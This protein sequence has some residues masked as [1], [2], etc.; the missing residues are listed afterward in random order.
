MEVGQSTVVENS[1]QINGDHLQNIRYETS[2]P[3]RNNK[4]EYLKGK[5]NEL[6]TNNK[7]NNIRYLYR[8]INQFRKGYQPGINIIKHENGN[9]LADPQSVLNRWKDFLNQV[10]N[11]HGIQD[12]R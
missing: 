2:R 11:V 5:I 10:L 3:F 9:V 7:N 1:S 6:E 4:R 12:V 8:G